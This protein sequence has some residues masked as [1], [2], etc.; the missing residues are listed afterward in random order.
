MSSQELYCL[1][2]TELNFQRIVLT[3][4]ISSTREEIQSN[5]NFQVSQKLV[6]GK[7]GLEEKSSGAERNKHT[8]P[9]YYICRDIST[10]YFLLCS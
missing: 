2:C 6:A 9:Y 10:F 1:S 4:F 3:K 5:K 7:I 8:A